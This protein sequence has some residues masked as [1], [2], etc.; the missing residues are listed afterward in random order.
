MKGKKMSKLNILGQEYDFR[1]TTGREDDA[2]LE[3]NK[4]LGEC[5]FYEKEIVV[6]RDLRQKEYKK[7]IIRHEIIHAFLHESGLEKHKFDEDLINYIAI[8][9]PKML[10]VF[11]EAKGL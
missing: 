7:Q 11:K 6:Y 5:R 4:L 1:L 3:N 9:F 10:K 8:Q 2:M